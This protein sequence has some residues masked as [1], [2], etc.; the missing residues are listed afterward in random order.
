VWANAVPAAI[1]TWTVN[2]PDEARRLAALGV[3][4][5]ITDAPDTILAAL[6]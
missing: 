1:N 6:A 4:T 3:K 2:D 5:I